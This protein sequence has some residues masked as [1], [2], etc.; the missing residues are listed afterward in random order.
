MKQ[1]L[2][3]II[4]VN[5]IQCLRCKDILISEH[6]HHYKWCK[7]RTCCVYGGKTILKRVGDP[8]NFKEL[9]DTREYRR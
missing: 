8:K 3:K 9:S 5:K 6:T 7:C 1:N 4:I 2:I